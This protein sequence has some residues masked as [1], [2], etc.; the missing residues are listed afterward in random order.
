MTKHIL[1]TCD[2]LPHILEYMQPAVE[3]ARRRGY[4]IRGAYFG[5]PARDVM[6]TM[7]ITD[8]T[9]YRAN[10]DQVVKPPVLRIPRVQAEKIL[11]TDRPHAVFIDMTGVGHAGGP[12]LE[13]C[14]KRGITAIEFGGCRTWVYL[15]SKWSGAVTDRYIKQLQKEGYGK[16]S[17]GLLAQTRA[18]QWVGLL[19][20]DRLQK[21]LNE[22][23]FKKSLG[24]K[25][26]QKYVLFMGNWGVGAGYSNV[27]TADLAEWDLMARDSGKVLVYSPH[28]TLFYIDVPPQI[29]PKS[30]ILTSSFPAPL[31]GHKT[32]VV[33]TL[34]LVRA[35][36]FVIYQY[37]NATLALCVAARKPTWLRRRATGRGD[38]AKFSRVP[39]DGVSQ[40]IIH[41]FVGWPYMERLVKMVSAEVRIEH[42]YRTAKELELL[43]AGKL[44]F[45]CSEKQKARWEREWRMKL[46]GNAARRV[47]DL[48]DFPQRK[49]A[50][51]KA[52]GGSDE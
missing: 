52:A 20:G 49:R 31:W 4:E 21:P 27:T 22:A 39:W 42:C 15:F 43:F 41:R 33:N 18:W 46:D 38:P 48:I 1:V 29:I 32:T 45:V 7:G 11:D 44:D 25:P 24:L 9:L 51:E 5:N 34:D 6:R 36:E 30:T 26:N 14:R 40:D 3:E 28:P 23:A 19:T 35:S 37:H 12:W 17:D 47:M 16:H 50:G 10:W 2:Y 13:E 8:V